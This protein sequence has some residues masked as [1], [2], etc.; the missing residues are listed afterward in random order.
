[1]LRRTEFGTDRCRPD[2]GASPGRPQ[3]HDKS[4][5][6]QWISTA[7]AQL[8]SSQLSFEHAR[9]PPPTT[10]RHITILQ[11]QITRV[12]L[13][14]LPDQGLITQVTEITLFLSVNNIARTR[15]KSG[16]SKF[17]CHSFVLPDANTGKLHRLALC[18]RVF[19]PSSRP[20]PAEASGFA[21][22]HRIECHHDIPRTA[23]RKLYRIRISSSWMPWL[24][25]PDLPL[26][27]SST[28]S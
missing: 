27:I 12:K 3:W 15:T 4:R 14:Y 8:F 10:T 7:P 21:L 22:P 24:F 13:Y 1:M 28:W 9:K 18:R 11:R 23:S 26:I 5:S 16:I 20:D 2:G 6:P 25:A 19:P 17:L